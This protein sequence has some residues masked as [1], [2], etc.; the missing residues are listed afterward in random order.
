MPEYTET[1]ADYIK[2][3]DFSATP[4]VAFADDKIVFSFLGD[5]SIVESLLWDFGDYASPET[6]IGIGPQTV[7]Y[8]NVGKKTVTLRIYWKTGGD[9]ILLKVAYISIENK[10]L[11]ARYEEQKRRFLNLPPQIY[12]NSDVN[13]DL[14]SFQY[15]MARVF[16]GL[17]NLTENFGSVIDPMRARLD[18]LAY[19][20]RNYGYEID[21]E[22]L[23]KQRSFVDL[24]I[25]YTGIKGARDSF[26]ALM[27]SYGLSADVMELYFTEFRYG[28][29]TDGDFITTPSSAV[30]KQKRIVRP[31]D[32]S[33]PG[34][35]AIPC[36][37]VIPVDGSRPYI[38]F[39]GDVTPYMNY[40]S[41]YGKQVIATTA[42][43]PDPKDA[44]NE[45]EIF[46]ATIYTHPDTLV[47]DTRV[48]VK[49]SFSGSGAAMVQF[50]DKVRSWINVDEFGVISPGSMW[51]GDQIQVLY[52]DIHGDISGFYKIVALS[53]EPDGTITATLDTPI[54]AELTIVSGELL[55][56]S[57]MSKIPPQYVIIPKTGRISKYGDANLMYNDAILFDEKIDNPFVFAS[58]RFL[59]QFFTLPPFGVLTD[60]L[61]DRITRRVLS[62]K[63]IES[64]FNGFGYR[65]NYIGDN[66]VDVGVSD[67]SS[68]T[69]MVV[70]TEMSGTVG[71]DAVADNHIINGEGTKFLTELTP[72]EYVIIG[73]TGDGNDFLMISQVKSVNTD[74]VF[75][76]YDPLPFVAKSGIR[77]SKAVSRKN[78]DRTYTL[79][80]K[81]LLVY[82]TGSGADLKHWIRATVPSNEFPNSASY[83]WPPNITD[84][85]NI[86][87]IKNDLT[88]SESIKTLT[89][90]LSMPINPVFI[91]LDRIAV[92]FVF[93]VL[94]S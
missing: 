67:Y 31:P 10:F 32:V 66:A 19:L 22:D 43:V 56:F 82:D 41:P 7:S 9:S 63:P 50:K 40:Y 71:F 11:I 73:Y 1:K 80:E 92:F 38:L 53:K 45:W 68:A 21:R 6:A 17:R 46:Y 55:P 8:S 61:L 49:G 52:G 18:L 91:K 88:F 69:K 2:V 20:S 47:R 94:L 16:E 14:K 35:G 70:G 62:M 54:I 75:E 81:R 83:D 39:S 78:T 74:S 36:Q 77:I 33:V 59:I 12:R 25:Q 51:V 89:P 72:G 76:V 86:V 28:A 90:I 15:V 60:P 85:L 13:G 5:T 42:I 58:N 57:A 29:K 4:R 24:A 65:V 34:D 93:E 37:I 27:R 26:R 30:I 87:C 44:N 48:Y 79:Y 64:D 23:D 84:N 3:V